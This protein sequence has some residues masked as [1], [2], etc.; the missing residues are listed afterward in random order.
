M[1]ARR[2]STSVYLEYQLQMRVTM[3][4]SKNTSRESGQVIT[5]SVTRR[6]TVR[7]TAGGSNFTGAMYARH[8]GP[9][10]FNIRKTHWKKRDETW[11][12]HQVLVPWNNFPMTLDMRRGRAWSERR[13]FRLDRLTTLRLFLSEQ[14]EEPFWFSVPLLLPP[15]DVANVA[16][17]PPGKT[18]EALESKT[19][20]V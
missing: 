9:E 11:G 5:H 15:P 16:T 7:K 18:Y 14:V 12:N 2:A 17:G 4:G 8:G 3:M 13:L 19:S 1:L 20:G 6:E 10:R